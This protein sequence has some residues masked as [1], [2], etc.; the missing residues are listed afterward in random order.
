MAISIKN[1]QKP[2]L[3]ELQ[4]LVDIYIYILFFLDIYIYMYTYIHTYIHTVLQ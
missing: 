2:H 4:T 1:I 3:L